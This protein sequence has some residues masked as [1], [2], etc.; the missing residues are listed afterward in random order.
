MNKKSGNLVCRKI[1]KKSLSIEDIMFVNIN[2]ILQ[3]MV[4]Y[5]RQLENCM[6]FHIDY[7]D[8]KGNIFLKNFKDLHLS[9]ESTLNW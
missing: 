3:S 1:L 5:K 9:T 8:K 7:F 6:D 2:F 4:R